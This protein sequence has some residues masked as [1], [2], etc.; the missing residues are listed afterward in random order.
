MT[1]AIYPMMSGALYYLASRA[2]ITR[3][4]WS[5]YPKWLDNFTLCAACLGFWLSLALG[6]AGGW[7]LGLPFLGLP[8]RT[9]YTPLVVAVCGIV[10]TPPIAY[11]VLESLARLSGGT[12]MD[13]VPRVPAADEAAPQTTIDA[14]EATTISTRDGGN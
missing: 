4:L 5:R 1:W 13:A 3:W 7:Y 2:E 9:L 12:L 6:V 14:H 11:I 10:W 8:G